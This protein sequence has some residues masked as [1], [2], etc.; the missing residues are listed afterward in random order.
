MPDWCA[1][2]RRLHPWVDPLLSL[3]DHWRARRALRDLSD[4]DYFAPVDVPYVPQFASP[5][6]IQ[7]YIHA[8][9]D[10]TQDPRWREFGAPTPQEYTFWAPRVC[11]LAVLKMAVSAFE[12][13]PPPDP[14]SLWELVQAGL[15]LDGYT[16]H[17]EAG[18]WVDQGW[19]VAAQRQLA[20]QYGLHA[21]PHGNAAPLSVCMAIRAGCLVAASVTPEIGERTP[22]RRRYGGHSV[23]VYGFRWQD[24]RPAVYWLHNPSGR[25]P[26]LQDGAQVDARRFH[27]SFAHR[28]LAL[29]P[30]PRCLDYQNAP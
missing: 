26:E 4:G 17:D 27:A 16:L 15:A 30:R 8:G 23:L 25:Y 28:F 1:F 10:G 2:K 18:S 12:T 7:A 14:P 29:S 3:P 6:H 20:T 24:N 21:E 5:E 19:Y 13:H 11:A 22:Q 9:Y